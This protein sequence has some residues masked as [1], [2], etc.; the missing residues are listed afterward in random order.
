MS[1]GGFGQDQ[2]AVHQ[3]AEIPIENPVQQGFEAVLGRLQLVA[4]E[5]AE[6]EQIAREAFRFAQAA[7][8]GE[9]QEL[10]GGADEPTDFGFYG[11]DEAECSENVG[12]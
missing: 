2:R 10:T 6:T 3:V 7:V 9:R 8:G 5:E 1:P 4:L 11:V 12:P